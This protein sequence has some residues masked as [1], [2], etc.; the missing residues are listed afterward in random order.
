[1]EV[2]CIRRLGKY[3]E[4]VKRNMEENYPTRFQELLENKTID[5]RLS[6]REKEIINRKHKIEEE[7]MSKYPRP[8]TN[9]FLMIAKYNQMI[10]MI[11][12]E[13]IKEDIEEI[14]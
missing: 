4:K 14:I 3:G 13:L 10:E 12:E 9:E 8:L 11:T 5:D 7:L 2:I 1:M 6:E